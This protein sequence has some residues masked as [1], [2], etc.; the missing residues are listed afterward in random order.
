V[1][2]YFSGMEHAVLEY[3][4]A[5]DPLRSA[6]ITRIVLCDEDGIPLNVLTTA[7]VPNL[8]IE[9]VVR[10]RRPDL[11]LAFVLYDL[12]QNPIFASCPPDAGVEYPTQPGSYK[13][14][15]SFPGQLLMPQRYSI[16]V[17]IY[18]N[19]E[20]IHT[21]LH[22]LVFDIAA[23]SGQVYSADQNRMGVLQILCHW[24]QRG[25]RDHAS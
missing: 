15:A 21:C 14:Q 20:E 8:A 10:E 9:I 18:S 16:S 3:R 1:S 2:S 23:T 25:F 6:E 19:T 24:K 12:Q 13:F 11:K 22:A 4:P 7:D 17:A 5:S